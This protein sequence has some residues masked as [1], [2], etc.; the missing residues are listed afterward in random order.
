MDWLNLLDKGGAWAFALSFLAALATGRLLLAR[1]LEPFRKG[2]EERDAANKALADRIRTL[3][4]EARQL[5]A[6]TKTEMTQQMT[7]ARGET[8]EMRKTINE[9][10]TRL[11]AEGKE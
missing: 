10:M 5:A 9:L 4:M 6:D 3:E 7:L 11:L 8:S 1:E 2:L